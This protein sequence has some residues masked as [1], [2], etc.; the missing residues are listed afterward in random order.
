MKLN[1]TGVGP[2][3]HLTPSPYDFGNQLINTTGA[4]VT[5][6]VTN[7]AAATGDL[8]TSSW[9]ITGTDASDFAPAAGGSCAAGGALIPGASCTINYTFTPAAHGARTATFT[10]TDSTS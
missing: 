9:A 2:I 7:D 3:V 8:I 10:L 1:G 5:L 4:A 6:T